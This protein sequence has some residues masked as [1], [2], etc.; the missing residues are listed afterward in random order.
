MQATSHSRAVISRGV[1]G[2][3]RHADGFAFVGPGRAIAAVDYL[4][5]RMNA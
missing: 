1:V 4:S 2:A 3:T 5:G